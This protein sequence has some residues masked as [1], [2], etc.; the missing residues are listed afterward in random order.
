MIDSKISRDDTPIEACPAS[1][2]AGPDRAA[3]LRFATA[4]GRLIGRQLA[5]DRA[6]ASAGT[7]T[8]RQPPGPG[9]PSERY[10]RGR[11]S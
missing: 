7:T 4:L 3:V 2:T 11:N 1:D 6:A 9:R 5:A 8:R 10:L